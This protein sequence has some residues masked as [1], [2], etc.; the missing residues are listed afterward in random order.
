ME[1]HVKQG[2]MLSVDENV[3]TTGTQD[4]SNKITLPIPCSWL[5]EQNYCK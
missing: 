4:P 3:V 2:Y 1:T 5:L